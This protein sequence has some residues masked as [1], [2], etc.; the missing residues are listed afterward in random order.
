MRVKSPVSSVGGKYFLRKWLNEKLPEHKL[1]CEPFVG[2]GHLLFRKDE[3][4]AEVLNDINGNLIGFYKTLQDT[5]KRT[6]LTRILNAMP[7]SRRTWRDLSSR[8]AYGD[9]P[10]DEVLRVA[11]WFYLSR[12]CFSGDFRAGGFSAPSITGR[13]PAKTLR[14]IT[15]TLNAVAK[16]LRYVTFENLGYADCIKKYDSENTLFY[17]DPPYLDKEFFYEKNCF[18][19]EDHYALA[20]LLHN[21]KSKV[22]VSHYENE[23]YDKLYAGWVRHEYESFK[24]SKGITKTNTAST[25]PRTVEVLYCNSG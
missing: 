21:A 15:D 13:N 9:L 4:K 2:G 12:T 22:M 10:D 17:C 11:E 7:Y 16:R 3:S 14:N 24:V 20:E 25:R 8:W 19:E 6:R 1:Y 5:K 18:S 23:V